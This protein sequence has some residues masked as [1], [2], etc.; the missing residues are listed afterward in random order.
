MERYDATGLLAQLDVQVRGVS[1]LVNRFAI[2]CVYDI[3]DL[4]LVTTEYLRQWIYGIHPTRKPG[5]VEA[6]ARFLAR[7]E[8]LRTEIDSRIHR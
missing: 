6:Q 1:D 5:R 7:V 8:S 3:A 2:H 4:Q